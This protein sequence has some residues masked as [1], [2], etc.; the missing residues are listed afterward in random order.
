MAEWRV[1]N[2]ANKKVKILCKKFREDYY[3]E[4]VEELEDL[5]NANDMWGYYQ[6]VAKIIEPKLKAMAASGQQGGFY[7]RER[8]VGL[9][10]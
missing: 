8:M 5:F 4:A 9:I 1:Y 3:A 6:A 7:S 2:E 10:D